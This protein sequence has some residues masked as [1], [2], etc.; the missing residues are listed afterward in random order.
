MQKRKNPVEGTGNRD[1]LL[2]LLRNPKKTLNGSHNIYTN[3]LSGK[4][5]EH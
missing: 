5:R 2:R 3:D 4:K 1:P